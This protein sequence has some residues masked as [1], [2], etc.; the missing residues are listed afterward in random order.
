MNDS[1][2]AVYATG[3]MG[4]LVHQGNPVPGGGGG[5]GA[6]AGGGGGSKRTKGR[7]TAPSVADNMSDTVSVQSQD[8]SRSIAFSLSSSRMN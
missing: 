8:D 2:G 4:E 5:G 1:F 7:Y 6:T 3:A